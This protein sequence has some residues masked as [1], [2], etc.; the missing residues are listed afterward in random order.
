MS[1]RP[2]YTCPRHHINHQGQSPEK[3]TASKLGLL[4]FLFHVKTNTK[5][6][7]QVKSVTL[8]DNN[9]NNNNNNDD[10]GDFDSSDH[11]ARSNRR[12]AAASAAAAAVGRWCCR[13]MCWNGTI[14]HRKAV[15]VCE[16]E[17]SVRAAMDMLGLCLSDIYFPIK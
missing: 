11:A 14:T 16:R 2:P 8:D 6:N 9:N 13:E 10:D 7:T 15:R 3:T 12:A 17:A 1:K 4:S 5:K